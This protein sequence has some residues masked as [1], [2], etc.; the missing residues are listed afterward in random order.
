MKDAYELLLLTEP[1]ERLE[2]AINLSVADVFRWLEDD[3]QFIR[4]QLDVKTMLAVQDDTPPTP[5]VS[6]I[7]C[8]VCGQPHCA[9]PISHADKHV[10]GI[11]NVL[12]HCQ[13]WRQ[14]H[15]LD[16]LQLLGPVN[17]RAPYSNGFFGPNHLPGRL[18]TSKPDYSNRDLVSTVAPEATGAMRS[19]VQLLHLPCFEDPSP[20]ASTKSETERQLAPYALLATLTK[21]FAASL[22]Q[23]GLKVALTDASASTST[24]PSENRSHRKMKAPGPRLLTPSHVIRGITGES[25]N[26]ASLLLAEMGVSRD[27]NS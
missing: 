23:N 3:G 15:M 10:D 16:V 18:A 13:L 25:Q 7:L 26:A 6:A 4:P 19:I 2:D 22:V 12:R 24:A 1:P 20:K 21:R 5:P 8:S 9:E 17:P 11:C 27:E 14:V